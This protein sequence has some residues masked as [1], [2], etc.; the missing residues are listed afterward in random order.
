L[1]HFRFR[2]ELLGV[3]LLSER[4]KLTNGNFRSGRQMFADDASLSAQFL[5]ILSVDAV[6]SSM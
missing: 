6:T 3:Q 5:L 2:F 4:L 1:T